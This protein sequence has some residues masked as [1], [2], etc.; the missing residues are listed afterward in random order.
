MSLHPELIVT[1]YSKAF[2]LPLA[3]ERW[4]EQVEPGLSSAKSGNY[5]K[6]YYPCLPIYQL[7]GCINGVRGRRAWTPKRLPRKPKSAVTLHPDFLL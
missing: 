2:F 4:I 1:D 6:S 7:H 5:I 3:A